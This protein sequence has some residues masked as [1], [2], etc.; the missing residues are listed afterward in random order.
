MRYS[1]RLFLYAPLVVLAGLALAAALLWHSVAGGLETA[2]LRSN[3]HEIAPGVT[4][5]F[6]HESIGGFPFN[7][8]AVLDDATFEVRGAFG[9]ARWHTEHFAL[10]ELTFGPAQQI[11]E[12]AG[13][14]T[15]DWRDSSRRKHHF[16]FFPGSLQASAVS[17]HGR[18]VRFDLDINGIGSREVTG[19]RLQLHFRKSPGHDAIDVVLSAEDLHLA[20]ALEAGFGPGLSQLFVQGVSVRAAPLADLFAGRQ[21]WISALEKWRRNKGTFRVDRVDL[22]WGAVRAQGKGSVALDDAHRAAGALELVITGVPDLKGAA[23]GDAHLAHALSQLTKVMPRRPLHVSASI[24]SGAVNLAITR[25]PQTDV[26]AG[27]VG[28]LY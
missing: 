7:V 22:R 26:S 16:V 6:A 27:T 9:P 2:L 3:G 23:P 5:R 8:D 19:A 13:A 24:A 4:L 20:P 12:A 28:A 21:S 25:M 10:H 1:S 11:Y 14:Q 18:L 15:L 17:S